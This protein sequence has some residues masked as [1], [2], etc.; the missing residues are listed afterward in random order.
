MGTPIATTAT[1]VTTAISP[2]PK[3]IVRDICDFG[4]LPQTLAAVLKVINN[5]KS[6]ADEV[7]EIISQDVSLTTRL[8]RMVNSVQYGRNRKVSK[9]SEAVVVMGLNSVKMLALSSS[10]FSMGPKPDQDAKYDLHR[11]WRHLIET[12]VNARSIAEAINYREPEEAFVAGLLHDVGII[13]M[14]IHFKEQYCEVI[15][16]MK[17]EMGGLSVVEKARF[18]VDHCLVGAELI[19]AWRLPLRFGYVVENHHNTDKPGI[20]PDDNELNE[21]VALADRMAMEPLDGYYPNIEENIKFT[22][23]LEHKLK[24]DSE[25]LA[26]IRKN[27]VL[28]MFEMAENLELDIGEMHAIL[29]QMQD[30]MAALYMSMEKIYTRKQ[31][32]EIERLKKQSEVPAA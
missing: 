9:I 28:K 23:N 20:V 30:R 24:I 10:V 18:G 7:A 5:H 14:L 31:K 22:C 32:S 17:S 3:E 21:I 15:E 26:Q 4:S 25:K 6:S 29:S 27:S 19:K 16:Q 8:L 2:T 1:T 11:L 13:L 12:A